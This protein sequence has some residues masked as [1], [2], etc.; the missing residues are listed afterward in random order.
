V[1]IL[2]AAFNL[3]GIL[4]GIF[5]MAGW[6]KHYYLTLTVPIMF[7]WVFYA[8]ALGAWTLLNIILIN[9][10]RYGYWIYVGAAGASL[11][12]RYHFRIYYYS[13]KKI[14]AFILYM[15]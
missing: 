13:L 2:F 6:K 7:C 11:I 4:C 15:S 14:R 8:S 12:M 9:Q 5:I 3:Y 1:S 10:V